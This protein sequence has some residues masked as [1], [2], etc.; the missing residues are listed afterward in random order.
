VAG[1]SRV[2]AGASGAREVLIG[3]GSPAGQAPTA[4]G[5]EFVVLGFRRRGIRAAIRA[6]QGCAWR[7]LLRQ[8]ASAVALDVINAG[9]YHRLE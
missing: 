4:G 2:F 7:R 6:R 1:A 5:V 3:K 8:A 9:R